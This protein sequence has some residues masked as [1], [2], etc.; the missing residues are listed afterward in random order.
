MTFEDLVTPR[1]LVDVDAFEAN[2]GAA[3]AMFGSTDKRLRPHVKT[4]RTPGLALKQLGGA[5]GGVTCATVGEAEAM[6]QAGIA[7]LLIANEVID[8]GKLA[9]LARLARDARVVVAVDSA[10]GVESLAAAA[11]EAGSTIDVLVDVDVGLGRCGV[12]DAASAAALAR[13]VTT[14]PGLRFG[15]LMGYEGRLRA[16]TTD[17]RGE[18]IADAYAQLAEIKSAL[19]ATGFDV[20]T[21]SSAGTSTLDEAL[22]DPTVTEIQAGTYALMEHD[23]DGLGLPFRPATWVVGTVISRSPGRAVLDVG[24]KSVACDYGLPLPA[25]DGVSVASVNEEHTT[26]ACDGTPPELGARVLLQPSHVRLTFNLHDRVSLVRGGR[27]EEELPV[28]ARGGSS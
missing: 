15:G 8:P 17:D 9:R 18:R 11:R 27:V 19:E 10:T 14:R 26:L 1:L 6:A 21:V 12:P 7:D 22:A 3:E 25:A 23:L 5:A 4:H 13:H 24:R 16:S 28:T 20:G 2:V